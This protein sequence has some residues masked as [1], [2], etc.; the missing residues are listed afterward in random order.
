MTPLTRRRLL[1]YLAGTFVLGAIA[2]GAFGFGRSQRPP[3]KPFDREVM[4]DRICKSLITDLE[5]TPDQQVKLD[6]I[7]RRNMEEFEAVHR[8]HFAQIGEV[9]KRG[10]ERIAAILTPEQQAKFE[11]MEREREKQRRKDRGGPSRG[12]KSEKF[13]GSGRPPGSKASGEK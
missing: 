3:S 1:L 10:R 2:G 6:P 12:D 11:A 4:R 9:M 7:I 5:L 13:G 8:D